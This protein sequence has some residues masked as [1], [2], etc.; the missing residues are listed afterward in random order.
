MLNSLLF[1]YGCTKQNDLATLIL[2]FFFGLFMLT[3]HGWGKLANFSE[4]S[5]K[6]GDPLGVG[7]ELSLTL[8]VFAEVFCAMF[9]MIG[10][11]TRPALI[12]L[13]ITMAVIVFIHHALDPFKMK[14]LAIIYM[15]GYIVL[16]IT[17]PGKY[18]FDHLIG[19][20]LEAA[21]LKGKEKAGD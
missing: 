13:I 8:A 5:G 15:I 6:F 9:V 16:F 11:F 4:R 17:G 19:K 10:L 2:R 14:E 18:S 7:T 21:K 12:P 20:R 3:A 1:S